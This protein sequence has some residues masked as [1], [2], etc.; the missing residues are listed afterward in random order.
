[1]RILHGESIVQSRNSLVVLEATAK[2]ASKQIQSINA[3]N[4]DL[5]I[6]EQLLGSENLFAE[7]QLLVIEELHSLPKS[8]K[9]DALIEMLGNFANASDTS[10]GNSGGGAE[11]TEVILWEK[12]ELTPTMLKKFPGA[13]A[14]Q[15][16]L[17]SALVSWLDSCGGND[18]N[19]QM[20]L[21]EKA[22]VSDGDFMCFSMLARQVRLLIQAKDGGVIAGAPFV[23]S[24][25]KSQCRAFSIDQ[26]LQLHSQ[27][28]KI[29]L[30]QKTSSSKFNLAQELELLV[31]GL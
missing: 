10:S 29:D 6:L 19:R 17:S 8:K 15:F 3:K 4:L 26:L 13:R 16:K 20:Q 14:D 1:M 22:L 27:L 7:P 12:R 28:L 25:L 31:V 18:K 21:L 11:S 23:I 30:G 2:E 9:K 24:K 5:P